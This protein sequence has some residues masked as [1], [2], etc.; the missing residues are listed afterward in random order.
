MGTSLATTVIKGAG[1]GGGACF[2]SFLQA[3]NR[4]KKTI[5][6]Q[7]KLGFDM[8]SIIFMLNDF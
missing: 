3:L 6:D 8:V 2:S 4:L 5:S 1:I 7:K